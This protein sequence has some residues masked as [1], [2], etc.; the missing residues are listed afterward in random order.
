MKVCQNKYGI[1]QHLVQQAV[2]TI[3]G[4]SNGV[5]FLLLEAFGSKLS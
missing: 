2:I 5:S 1:V 3:V 4:L